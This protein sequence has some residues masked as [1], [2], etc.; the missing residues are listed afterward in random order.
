M[1]DRDASQPRVL[2]GIAALVAT[3]AL[4]GSNH[5]VS[6]AVR[7]VVP[8]PSMVFWRWAIGATI[9]TLIALPALRPAWPAIRARLGELIVG[10]VVG[11]GI[12]SYLLI[13]GAYRS[14]A[15][16]V[17]FINA[18]TP[19]WVALLGLRMGEGRVPAAT[20]AALAIAFAG[21]L[22]IITKG[23]PAVI[24]ELDF[25]LGNLLS[26]LAAITFA[27]FSL[28]LRDWT[29]TIDALPLSVVTAWSA[30]LLVFLPV[31][32]IW[33]AGGGPWLVWPGESREVALGAIAYVA[34]GP[35]M[36]GNLFYLY[37]VATN[38]PQRAAVFLYLSPVFSAGFAMIW[39]GEQL[40]WF[41]VAGFVAIVA[42]LV[43]L[44]RGGRVRVKPA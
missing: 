44:N 4:W 28:R 23:D 43:L 20:W 11:V 30:L 14:I 39:L 2:L 27:W 36:L 24:A 42:G 15:I 9:L 22:L 17:G 18:T 1:S 21:T 10:G 32:L 8:L 12:F 33:L 7:D 3:G 31:Y 26:L 16:E 34:L 25:N 6:R 19:I 38:G 41:H 29:R 5:V 35:T 40:A 37:G 13:G